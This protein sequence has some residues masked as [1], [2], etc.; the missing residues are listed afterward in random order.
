MIGQ[1]SGR[2]PA[3]PELAM[4][5]YNYGGEALHGLWSTCVNSSGAAGGPLKCP[6]QFG[7]PLSMG[8]S[9]NRR[10]WRAMADATSTEIRAF[11]DVAGGDNGQARSLEGTPFG[12]SYYAPNINVVRHPAC[13]CSSHPPGFLTLTLYCVSRHGMHPARALT[14]ACVQC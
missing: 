12:L 9:F 13:V 1:M 7:S 2:A 3:I 6:T 14:Y 5:E 10:L 4:I 8:C 11:Y